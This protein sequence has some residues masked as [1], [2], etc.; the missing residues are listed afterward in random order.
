[1]GLGTHEPPVK[2][3]EQSYNLYTVR[4][5]CLLPF[6][7]CRFLGC[8]DPRHPLH[9]RQIWAAVHNVAGIHRH[10]TDLLNC[11]AFQLMQMLMY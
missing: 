7:G 10:R 3:K 1:M 2:D 8:D 11:G 6:V 5:N 4:S 9:A